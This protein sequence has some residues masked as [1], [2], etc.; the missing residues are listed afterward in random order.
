MRRGRT[1]V[2]EREEILLTLRAK[3]NHAKESDETDGHVAVSSGRESDKGCSLEY[4][5]LKCN[6]SNCLQ[7]SSLV[8][9]W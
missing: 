1:H 5:Q 9:Y 4:L 3:K 7:L 6:F 8:A 2:G